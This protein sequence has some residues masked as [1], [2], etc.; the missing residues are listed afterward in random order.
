MNHNNYEEY[1]S[2]LAKQ[3]WAERAKDYKDYNKE[4]KKIEDASDAFIQILNSKTK[5]DDISEE[6]WK[7]FLNAAIDSVNRVKSKK[8]EAITH[9]FTQHDRIFIILKYH[10]DHDRYYAPAKKLSRTKREINKVEKNIADEKVQLE[11]LDATINEQQEK[12]N[13]INARIKE[14]LLSTPNAEICDII[15]NKLTEIKLDK[16]II[17]N[18]KKAI[19]A[20]SRNEDGIIIINKRHR[21]D[22]FKESKD[23]KLQ[24]G[25]QEILW[26]FLIQVEWHSTTPNPMPTNITRSEAKDTAI[27]QEVPDK[28]EKEK[29]SEK[30]K[31]NLKKLLERL[32]KMEEPDIKWY[33]VLYQKIF[34][35]EDSSIDNIDKLAKQLEE[36]LKKR[37]DLSLRTAIESDLSQRIDAYP[38]L[39][40]LEKLKW[41]YNYR[42][43]F[44]N[45]KRNLLLS[46]DFKIKSLLSY[47]DYKK[48]QKNK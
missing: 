46:W 17:K 44:C 29:I 12:L 21:D 24:D 1:R 31:N 5:P 42:I 36:A 43:S 3:L 41:T 20:T 11:T 6:D 10:Q 27:Q 47:E 37:T 35:Y 25:I 40:N 13:E 19:S 2:S 32:Q 23:F 7:D 33:I 45:S 22:W 30:R 39:V 34:K 15:H 38:Q 16:K 18:I 14:A 28:S 4:K 8:L 48:S 26:E 9:R